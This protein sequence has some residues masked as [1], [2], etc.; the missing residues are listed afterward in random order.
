MRRYFER[1]TSEDNLD[2]DGL[3]ELGDNG[4]SGYFNMTALALRSAERTNG[5]SELHG[6]VADGMWRNLTQPAGRSVGHITNGVHLPSWVGPE[7]YET[8]RRNL[9]RGFAQNLFDPGFHDAVM[10]IPDEEIWDAHQMQKR[11]LIELAREL[12]LAQFARHGRSPGELDQVDERLDPDAL[13][14]GFARRFATYKRADLLLRDMDRMREIVCRDDRPVQFLFAGKAHPADRPGQ[15]LIRRIFHASNDPA[16]CG[17]LLFLE[18]YDIRIGRGMVQGVDV[19]LNNPRRPLEASGTSGMKA[20]MN[21]G[22]NCSVLDGWWCEGYDAEHGWAIGAQ[23]RPADDE[24][25]DREDAEELYRLLQ[26]EIATC[27]YDRNAAGLPEAWIARMKK[28]IASL[29]PRFS[30]ARMVQEY[31]EQLYRPAAD[32]VTARTP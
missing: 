19:W 15:D 13:L 28:A 18:N 26:D 20:A 23:E 6:K 31:T 1:W 17:R 27:Y 24:T 8:L 12:A 9:G 30:T 29:S 16:L 14:I 4:D 3:L 22:L 7:I 32:G 11:Q 10:A 2:I 21:G 25:E 5:V